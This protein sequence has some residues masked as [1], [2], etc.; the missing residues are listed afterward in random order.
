MA[1]RPLSRLRLAAV[2]TGLALMVVTSAA[3]VTPDSG[4]ASFLSDLEVNSPVKGD[5]VVVGGDLILGPLADIEGHAVSL[6]GT[7]HRSPGAR[8]SGRTL[9]ISSI[10]TLELEPSPDAPW[11]LRLAIAMLTVG[12]W[13]SVVTLLAFLAPGRL[14]YG[15]WLLPRLGARVMV[16]GVMV[17]LTLIAAIIAVLGLGFALGLPLLVV[18]ALAFLATKAIGLTVLGGAIGA[19]ALRR[20]TRPLPLSLEVLFGAS[21]LLLLRFVPVAG[22]ILYTAASITA[23]GIGVFAVALAPTG[24]PLGLSLRPSTPPRD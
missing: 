14:R 17:Y 16:L 13:L 20:V 10:A 15:V 12:G 2:V 22:E 5:V 8:V 1:A 3:A 7:V 9:S 24:A 21:L 19:R 18:I 4:R 6:L 23:C 11:H